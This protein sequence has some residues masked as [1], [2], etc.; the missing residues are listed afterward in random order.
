MTTKND[1]SIEDGSDDSEDEVEST[2]R[3]VRV[4]IL[5]EE[6]AYQ[7]RLRV[8]TWKTVQGASGFAFV[9]G[10]TLDVKT[11][12]WFFHNFSEE[13]RD[14]WEKQRVYSSI[15]SIPV[16]DDARWVPIGVG[17]IASIRKEPFWSRLDEPELKNLESFV[18]ATFRNVID[19]TSVF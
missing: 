12:E 3:V 15:L 14:E 2:Q 6:H 13:K 7:R 5:K 17:C 11:E 16:Y 4:H 10:T 1:A 9:S 8:D 18:R 19:Y